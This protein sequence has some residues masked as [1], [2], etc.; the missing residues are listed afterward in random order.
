MERCLCVRANSGKRAPMVAECIVGGKRCVV[1]GTNPKKIPWLLM[2]C[3]QEAPVLVLKAALEQLVCDLRQSPPDERQVAHGERKLKLSESDGGSQ[4]QKMRVM[5]AGTLNPRTWLLLRVVAL[6][7]RKWL[8]Q[9]VPALSPSAPRMSRCLAV[10]R[11]APVSGRRERPLSR[12]PRSAGVWA[13]GGGP[14][15]GPGRYRR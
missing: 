7:P 3:S 11:E 14:R 12:R 15:W 4:P 10:G 6:S 5:R 8:V 9:R 13:R 1:V 2:G